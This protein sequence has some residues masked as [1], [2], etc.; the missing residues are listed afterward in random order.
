MLALAHHRLSGVNPWRNSK[1]DVFV[2]S[3]PNLFRAFAGR[4]GRLD[5]QRDSVPK[6]RVAKHEL[7]WEEVRRKSQPQRGCGHSVLARRATFAATASRLNSV[8]FVTQGSLAG[9][10]TLGWRTQSRWDCCGSKRRGPE[11]ENSPKTCSPSLVENFV[12]TDQPT[13]FG[14]KFS[15]KVCSQNVQTSRRSLPAK[16]TRS[17]FVE[18]P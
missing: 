11:R 9:S 15:T 14:P 4:L 3:I 16:E 12:E 13:K 18:L 8:R 1:A 6:P 17:Q 2:E 10:A 5:S 7:S